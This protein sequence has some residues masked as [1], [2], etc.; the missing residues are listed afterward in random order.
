MSTATAAFQEKEESDLFCEGF[1][2][3]ETLSSQ[4]F[5]IARVVRAWSALWTQNEKEIHTYISKKKQSL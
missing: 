1:K 5:L 2:E 3:E 4:N